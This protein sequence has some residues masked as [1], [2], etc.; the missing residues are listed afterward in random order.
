MAER[1]ERKRIRN[2]IYGFAD[3]IL[4]PSRETPTTD[5]FSL[6]G[7]LDDLKFLLTLGIYDFCFS[8]D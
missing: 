7:D 4:G 2:V 5:S 3:L 8:D 1:L 6:K